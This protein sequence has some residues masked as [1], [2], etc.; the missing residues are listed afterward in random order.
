VTHQLDK[1]SVSKRGEETD[2]VKKKAMG[3]QEKPNPVPVNTD[4]IEEDSQYSKFSAV[5][6]AEKDKEEVDLDRIS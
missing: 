2:G 3:K 1:G 5:V 4:S 6:S